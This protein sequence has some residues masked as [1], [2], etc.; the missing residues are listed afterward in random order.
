MNFALQLEEITKLEEFSIWQSDSGLSR[1]SNTKGSESFS[2]YRCE[3][4]L[5]DK[6][7]SIYFNLVSKSFDC[8]VK[9]SLLLALLLGTTPSE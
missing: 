8:V 2:R 1:L 7:N 9:S 3:M 5:N 6:L 4:T